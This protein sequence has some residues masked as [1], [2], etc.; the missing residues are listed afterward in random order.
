MEKLLVA[1][2]DNKVRVMLQSFV[3]CSSLFQPDESEFVH[4]ISHPFGRERIYNDAR[5][6]RKKKQGFMAAVL[7]WPYP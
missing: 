6:K 4:Y 7:Y 1:V 2:A 3:V 5:K